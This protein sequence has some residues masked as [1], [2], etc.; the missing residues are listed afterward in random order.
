MGTFSAVFFDLGKTLMYAKAPWQPVLLRSYKA[1]A[2]TLHVNGVDV[3][4]NTLPYEFTSRI[5]AYHAYRDD[6]LRET[7]VLSLL[8]HV[9]DENGFRDTPDPVLRTALNAKYAITQSNWYVENDA[10]PMLRALRDSDYRLALLSNAGDDPDVQALIDKFGLRP[11][12]EFILTSAACG[13][14][15]PHPHMFEQALDALN[16]FPHQ[17]A[18][19]GDALT[20]DVKGAQALGIYSIWVNRRVNIHTKTLSV[21]QP[22]ESVSAL[23]DIPKLLKEIQIP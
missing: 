14:R 15:K 3:D 5:N 9:L 10:H 16:L 23:S 17:V 18:M 13:Y 2:E 22:D 1:L 20:A 11:Y 12:F 6:T 4:L 19:V 21:I 7:T 8:R